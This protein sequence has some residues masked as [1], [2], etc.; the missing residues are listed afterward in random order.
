MRYP[1]E[2]NIYGYKYKV[3]LDENLIENKNAIGLFQS[4]PRLISIQKGLDSDT[5]Q[6]TY[7]HECVH[8]VLHRLGV[9]IL[10]SN[11]INEIITEGVS[12][13]IVDE[14]KNILKILNQKK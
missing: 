9:D 13:F 12:N 1:K 8:G 2:Q 7:L 10:I 14:K 4:K 3:K 5:G 6:R 11:E